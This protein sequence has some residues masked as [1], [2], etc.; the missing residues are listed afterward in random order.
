MSTK[1]RFRMIAYTGKS[2]DTLFWGRV[3]FDIAGMKLNDKLPALR[4]HMRDRPV[5]VIDQVA[6]SESQLVA[7]G[8]YL[9]SRDGEECRQLM[10]EG[11]PWQSSVGIW[12]KR[13]ERLEKGE[14]SEVNGKAFRGPGTIW[15]ASYVR[16]C[17]FVSLGAD[18]RTTIRKVAASQAPGV[19][20]EQETNTMNNEQENRR[21]GEMLAEKA[22]R[23][24]AQ[25]GI[26]YIEALYLV[27]WKNPALTRAYVDPCRQGEERPDEI[28]ARL[29]IELMEA[30][31]VEYT[32]AMRRV[33]R[34]HPQLI[35]D[36]LDI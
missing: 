17:S 15:R 35:A 33:C 28:L 13:V 5:G 26:P 21:P 6:K 18:D 10:V 29:S 22:T 31:G 25:K 12:V 30:E 16:E 1:N 19:V 32:V 2:V 36:Y 7:E 11:Y 3:V 24:A 14:A 23:L 8:F 20:A 34:Q 4:E 9:A 27:A